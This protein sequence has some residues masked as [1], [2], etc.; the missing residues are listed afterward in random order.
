MDPQQA[1]Y[2]LLDMLSNQPSDR[3]EV[4]ERLFALCDWVDMDGFLPVVR[5]EQGRFIIPVVKM[6]GA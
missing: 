1:L 5:K 2:E 3:E 4:I 6:G